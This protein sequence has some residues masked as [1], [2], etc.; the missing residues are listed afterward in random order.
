MKIPQFQAA[1][2]SNGTEQQHHRRRVTKTLKDPEVRGAPGAAQ[3]AAP[4]HGEATPA[5]KG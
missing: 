1:N 5:A 3:L 2:D 4:D